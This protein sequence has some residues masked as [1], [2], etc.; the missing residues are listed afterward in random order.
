MV[1]VDERRVFGR[2]RVDELSE[3]FGAVGLDA[4][5]DDL[6]RVTVFGDEFGAQCLPPGQVVAAASIGTPRREHHFAA[7]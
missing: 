3:R 5:R 7:L 2:C 1:V 6:D 4:D